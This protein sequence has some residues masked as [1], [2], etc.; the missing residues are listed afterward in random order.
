MPAV[1]TLLLSRFAEQCVLNTVNCETNILAPTYHHQMLILLQGRHFTQWSRKRKCVQPIYCHVILAASTT[2]P[3]NACTHIHVY[4]CV[5]VK[6]KNPSL[7]LQLQSVPPRMPGLTASILSSSGSMASYS[8]QKTL[9][10]TLTRS[11]VSAS[12]TMQESGRLNRSSSNKGA[13]AY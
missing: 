11:P 12:S 1:T 5:Q 9:L 7:L 10:T 4:A 6:L 3:G 8:P 2:V 13:W